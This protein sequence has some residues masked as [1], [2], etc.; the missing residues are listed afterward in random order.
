MRKSADHATCFLAITR[1]LAPMPSFDAIRPYTDKDVPA[2][3]SRLLCNPEFH[4]AA[5]KFFL[6]KVN[7]QLPR[8]SVLV[9]R[10]LLKRRLGK[11]QTVSDIQQVMEDYMA[12]LIRQTIVD[13]SV[14]GLDVLDPEVPHLFISNHR[15]IVMDTGIMNYLLR[16]AGHPTSRIAVGDNLLTHDYAADLMRMN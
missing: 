11:L 14:D 6:P 9:V 1:Y 2:V 3:M 12:G 7:R 13:L 8:L 15:D 4:Q 10:S 5:A 16:R